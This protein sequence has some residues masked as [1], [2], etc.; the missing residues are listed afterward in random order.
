MSDRLTQAQPLKIFQA[1]KGEVVRFEIGTHSLITIFDR[2]K[3]R[4]VG[5]A[6]PPDTI[7]HDEKLA[8][9]IKTLGVDSSLR[10]QLE[11]RIV[12][13]RREVSRLE[14][15]LKD[16]NVADVKSMPGRYARG[17]AFLFGDT[18]KM[19]VHLETSA[20]VEADRKRRVLI[21]DDSKT[22]RDILTRIFSEDARL[23]VVGAVEKPSLVFDAIDRL[24]PDVITLDVHMPEMDGVTLLKQLMPRYRLPVV[25][26]TSIRMEDGP[27]VLNALEIGAVDYIQKPSL[28]ELQQQAPMIRDKIFE[29]SKSRVDLAKVSM[30]MKPAEKLQNLTPHSKLPIVCIGSST[31][32]TE[33]LRALFSHFPEKIPPVVVVQHIPPV[34][35]Q[36]FAERLNEEFPFEVKEAAD[37]D[38]VKF[39]RILIAPGAKQMRL[40]EESGVLRVQLT[41]DAP[42]NRFKPSVDYLFDSAAQILRKRAVGVILTGMGADGAKGLLRMKEA[43]ARTVGQDEATSVV[44]GMPR[45]AHEIGAVDIQKPLHQI[46]SQIWKWLLPS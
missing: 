34:F 1:A 33:A 9:L 44:Y 12:A 39:G 42:V 6:L 28:P 3:H 32:G 43:G 45:V 16:L 23:E 22:I 5:I 7:A 31:G 14:K 38:E 11:A 40:K 15:M 36:A 20:D 30:S 24:K 17:E 46:A 21:V 18:G 26:V 37:G 35:S 10:P 25:M 27:V 19:K 13:Q 29:A 41:D 2:Q 4:S 8:E